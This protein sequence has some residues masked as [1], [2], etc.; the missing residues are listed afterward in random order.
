[1]IGNGDEIAERIDRYLLGRLPLED[2]QR[3][4]AEIFADE[5]VW[6][7]VRDGEDRLIERYLAGEL[8]AGERADF[9][10]HFAPTRTRQEQI[11]FTSTLARE[12]RSGEAR[13]VGAV[14]VDAYQGSPRRRV[15]RVA[16][17]AGLAAA[18]ILASVWL[19][20]RY[21]P[22]PTSLGVSAS[23]SSTPATRPPSTASDLGQDAGTAAPPSSPPLVASLVLEGGLVR[24]PGRLPRLPVRPDAGETR[25]DVVLDQAPANGEGTAALRT[26]E[27]KDLWT[28]RA[29]IAADRRTAIV[30]LPAAVLR[31]GDYLLRVTAGGRAS[32]DAAEYPFRVVRAR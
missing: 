31:P 23:T 15:S 3:L 21:T 1:M 17:W 18:L 22:G 8:S 24:G 13:E 30:V 19:G 14:T 16:P 32:D 25:I 12:A 7:A 6:E 5:D 20:G 29:V 10:I 11:A 28:G 9:E 27:G 26:V 4:E 2:R